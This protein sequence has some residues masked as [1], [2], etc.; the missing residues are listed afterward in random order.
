MRVSAIIDTYNYGRFIAEAIKSVLAQEPRPDQIL[1]VDD[2]STDHTPEIVKAF[3]VT[4]LRK[5]NGG[6]ASNLNFGISQAQGDIVCFLD[7]DDVWLPGKVRKVLE[8]FEK[9]PE[10]AM[11]QHFQKSIDAE[12]RELHD[13]SACLPRKAEATLADIRTGAASFSGT[14]ALSFRRE[15]LQHVGPIPEALVYCPD[16]FLYTHVH[17]YGASRHLPEVLSARRLHGSNPS[18]ASF[19]DPRKVGV[20]LGVREFQDARLVEA[21]AQRAMPGLESHEAE[22]RAFERRKLRA[23]QARFAGRWR[24]LH[25]AAGPKNGQWF[26]R[27]SALATIAASPALFDWLQRSLVGPLYRKRA[28]LG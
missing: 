20:F 12:G 11:V 4:Y 3:D 10:T 26:Y 27:L 16:E 9:H 21:F 19:R 7:A 1:V 17:F 25:L 22:R 6:Q 13:G 28:A 14:S 18:T 23:L 15:A 2:G 8:C 24:E 5:L